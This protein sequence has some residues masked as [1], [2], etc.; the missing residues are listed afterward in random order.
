MYIYQKERTTFKS[1]YKNVIY[2]SKFPIY[3]CWFN[4]HTVI[5]HTRNYLEQ[6]TNMIKT[7]LCT[8]MSNVTIIFK[9]SPSTGCTTDKLLYFSLVSFF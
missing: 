1:C 5:K 6:H 3:K 2:E 7:E 9:C 4:V 8:L